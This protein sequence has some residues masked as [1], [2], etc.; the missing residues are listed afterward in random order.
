[1]ALSRT[2]PGRG[3]LA[4]LAGLV[5][6]TVSACGSDE[7]AETLP[8]LQPTVRPPTLANAVPLTDVPLRNSLLDETKL[9]DGYIAL[10]D[11]P[12][13]TVTGAGAATDPAQCAKVLSPVGEQAPGAVSQ[14]VAQ[15]SGPDF[16]SV[17]IDAASYANGAAAQAF[18][19]VQS[20]LQGCTTFSGKD[21]DNVA[22]DFRLGGLEQPQ[23]GDASTAFRVQT[24]SQGFTLYTAVSLTMVGSTVV[25]IAMSGA[26]E[27]DPQRLSALTAEQVAKLR[28]AT[29]S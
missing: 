16:E 20:L 19:Q 24:S 21:A 5:A 25:Q 17:D 10:N 7:P 1:M 26:T 2:L 6:V 14:A 3:A 29:G 28:A 13:G 23:A 11:P 15:F 12:P 18:S 8:A 4:A 27:P 22:V 9:P